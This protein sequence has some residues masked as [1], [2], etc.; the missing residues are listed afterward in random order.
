MSSDLV[1]ILVTYGLS[2]P[3]YIVWV[4]GIVLALVRMQRYPKVSILV[5][6]ALTGFFFLSMVTPWAYRM[7]PR[8]L[9]LADGPFDRVQMFYRVV[10]FFHVLVDAVLFALL[11]LAVFGRR[12]DHPPYTHSELLPHDFP[13]TPSQ[14]P[15]A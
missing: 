15:R 9:D 4:V 2:F 5:L 7:L 14:P 8:L 11:L 10:G 3:L 1:D 12:K 6:V 13:S